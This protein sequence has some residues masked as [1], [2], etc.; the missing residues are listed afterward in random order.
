M[1]ASPETI[2]LVKRRKHHR[3]YRYGPLFLWAAF[4]FLA[5]SSLMSASN[6]RS[7]L[8]PILLGLFPHASEATISLIHFVLR[9]AGHFTEYAILALLAA[10]ALR[11]SSHQILSHR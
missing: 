3:L 9:K 1:S 6:T 7:I 4:I 2:V 11:T 8:R 5:S 10:R